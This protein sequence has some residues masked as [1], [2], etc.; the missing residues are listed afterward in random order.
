A[1]P[2][3]PGDPELSKVGPGAARPWVRPTLG[4]QPTRPR[5]SLKLIDC[6]ALTFSHTRGRGIFSARSP[7]ATKRVKSAAG[8]RRNHDSSRQSASPRLSSRFF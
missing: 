8:E 2:G 4:A 1:R 3:L 6:E 7:H 5:S